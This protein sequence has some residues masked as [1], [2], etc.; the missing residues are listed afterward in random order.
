[1][2]H[3]RKKIRKTKQYL[4]RLRNARSRKNKSIKQMRKT[5]RI[6]RGGNTFTPDYNSYDNMMRLTGA[7]DYLTKIKEKQEGIKSARNEAWS[8]AKSIF[9]V[10]NKIHK[11]YAIAL[12]DAVIFSDI[13]IK[14]TKEYIENLMKHSDIITT[15]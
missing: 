1:M 11:K 14:Q 10:D 13:I 12:D 6:M 5:K 8:R 7:E 4:I 15:K 2:K 3:T 9:S